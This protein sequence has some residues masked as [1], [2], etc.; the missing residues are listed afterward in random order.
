MLT[1]PKE[2]D[3]VKDSRTDCYGT[4][5]ISPSLNN[6]NV[7]VRWDSGDVTCID[8]C[9]LESPQN[10]LDTPDSDLKVGDWVECINHPLW[11]PGMIQSIRIV[12]DY[13]NDNDPP[14]EHIHKELRKISP[15]PQAIK[16]RFEEGDEVI[17]KRAHPERPYT[18]IKVLE[19][20]PGFQP[21]YLVSALGPA[22]YQDRTGRTAY[23]ILTE[24]PRLELYKN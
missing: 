23:Q 20:E 17:L 15:P 19:R 11:G 6:F 5:K 12:V 4:V 13:R 16:P 3:R 9:Y 1:K 10:N 8:Y 22:S 14:V 24:G 2:G 18:V 21:Q 7:Y